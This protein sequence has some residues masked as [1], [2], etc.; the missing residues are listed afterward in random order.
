VSESPLPALAPL[1]VEADLDLTVEGAPATVRSSGD[2]AVVTFESARGALRAARARPDGSASGI[3]TLLSAAEVTV[4]VRVRSAT[5]AV[6]GPG[7]SPG[8]LSGLL[9]AAPA[10]VYAVR[11]LRAAVGDLFGA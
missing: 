5:V 4:E 8:T 1:E 9:G 2:H 7:A 6:L 11:A 3:A 10:Q